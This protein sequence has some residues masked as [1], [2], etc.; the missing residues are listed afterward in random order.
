MEYRYGIQSIHGSL[1]NVVLAVSYIEEISPP[2]SLVAYPGPLYDPSEGPAP[3]E[4]RKDLT[5]WSTE[6]SYLYASSALPSYGEHRYD[7]AMMFDGNDLTAWNEGSESDGVEEEVEI[8]FKSSIPTNAIRFKA[9]FFDER[10]YE[11]NGRVKEIGVSLT[12]ES[13]RIVLRRTAIIPDGMKPYDFTFDEVK[14]ARA[15]FTIESIYPGKKWK[16][17]AISEIAFIRN[18]EPVTVEIPSELQPIL[19]SI[20]GGDTSVQKEQLVYVKAG[21]LGI[22]I[23][24]GNGANDRGLIVDESFSNLYVQPTWSPIAEHLALASNRSGQ[25]RIYETSIEN[26]ALNQISTGKGDHVAPQ[27]SPDGLQISYLRFPDGVEE[28]NGDVSL[29]IAN[30]DGSI[31]RE[32]KVHWGDA[33]G[34]GRHGSSIV[35]AS[36]RDGDYDIYRIALDGS[37]I[38]RLTS[39]QNDEYSPVVIGIP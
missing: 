11:D 35:F 2:Y 13:G 9:G 1:D 31:V 10:Y 24:D 25:W 7:P 27:W 12:D 15:H 29:V 28:E 21:G 14:V 3:R 19:G 22:N 34:G 36:N 20:P 33:Y 18:G 32:E 26:V 30:R 6:K 17:L 16:D 38:V 5:I 23:M 37:W 8:H 39:D 4:Q